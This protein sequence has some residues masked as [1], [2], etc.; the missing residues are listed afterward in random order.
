M[1]EKGEWFSILFYYCTV[2]SVPGAIMYQVLRDFFHHACLDGVRKSFFKVNVNFKYCE[3]IGIYTTICKL[4]VK[5]VTGNNGI[6]VKTFG[7]S[8]N[9]FVPVK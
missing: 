1:I 5:Q 2:R 3:N 4:K 7:G 8:P 6:C 9:V